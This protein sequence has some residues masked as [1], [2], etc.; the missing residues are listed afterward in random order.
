M[1]MRQ[2]SAE[3]EARIHE[4]AGEPF[5]VNSPKQLQ[6]ILFG[7]LGLKPVR[8]TK[9]GYSTDARVLEA[10]A[11]EHPVPHLILQNR[12]L[13]KLRTTYVDALPR[14]V[15]PRT[16]RLHTQ[17]H[18][19]VAA[20]GR[21]SS[22]DPN[23]Q[24]IPIR[25]EE[26]RRI[27][28]AFISRGEGWKLVSADY[29]QIELRILA[30]LSADEGLRRAF[31]SGVDIHRA[32]AAK[33]FGLQDDAVDSDTRR[34]AKAINFGIIYGMGAYG[35]SSRLGISIDEARLFIETYFEAFPRIREFIDRTLAET[36]A[37]GYVTTVLNRRRYFPEIEDK[38]RQVREF[39]ER[40]AVNT[41]IQGSAADLIKVAMIRIEER[42]HDA[43]LRSVMILQVHDELLFDVREGELD[44]VRTLVGEEMQGALL[45]DVPLL[46]DI[47]V[48]SNWLEAHE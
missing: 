10:L 44:R 28:A 43:G 9:T 7:K 5:N 38:N 33:I 12:E 39:A 21:L 4:E 36:R 30:H 41:A 3:L 22:S 26:G 1:E 25:T 34:R 16:H 2:R 42:L 31:A 40:A 19:T 15:H 32:T 46:V 17:F 27:R 37:R 29:S 35:L 6:E 14:M 47:G 13:V 18:Q 48:G 24:N 11:D 20:T 45:M 8:K 23:L